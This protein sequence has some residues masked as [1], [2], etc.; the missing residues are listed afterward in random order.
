MRSL[1]LMIILL[2]SLYNS[3]QKKA[4]NP[5]AAIDK[6]ALE[7]PDSL[8]STATDIAGYI[9]SN[10][11]SDSDKARAA[12][13]WIASNIE[14]DIDNMFAINFYEDKAEKAVKPL[15]TRKGICENY[16]ALFNHI[17]SKAGL[18]SYVLEGFTK[19]NG[20][21]DYIP[22][23]W[24]AVL[25]DSAWYICDA[26]WGSGYVSNGKFIRKINN[27]Y[28]KVLP[29]VSIK[30]HMPFDYLWQFLEYPATVQEFTEGK[31]FQDKNREYFNFN[32]SLAEL[33]ELDHLTK[34]ERS[35]SRI[36]KNGVRNSLIFDRLQHLKLEI[37]HYKQNQTVDLY[38][39]A[40]A[41]YNEAIN[42]LNEFINY[43]NVQFK[44]TKP[45]VALQ[46]MLD[47]PD[48]KLKDAAAKLKQIK[49][50][51]SNSAN[52]IMQLHKGIEDVSNEVEKQN[53]WLKLYLSKG[54]AG[55]KSM[56]YKVTWMGVPI[57]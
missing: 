49:Y 46:A 4:V 40:A 34:L 47:V 30:S 16:A 37:E 13:I 10:F 33:D 55:R 54:K 26:T 12:F 31:F 21:T 32:D 56:F 41:D 22:H 14:Y 48:S 19:Q 50:P 5:Y 6:K 35:V 9:S 45:D 43:R 28:F 17:C 44:P 38:N 25:L 23:A 7:I 36:E 29:S 51:N 8:T 53:T 3:A 2:A 27:D 52:S 24:N 15:K 20:F 42:L 39:S 57:N 18:R 11:Q 1:A